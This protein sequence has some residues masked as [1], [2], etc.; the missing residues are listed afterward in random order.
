MYPDISRR[1]WVRVA[2]APLWVWAGRV[3]SALTIAAALVNAGGQ[4]VVN[5]GYRIPPYRQTEQY[6]PSVLGKYQWIAGK[7]EG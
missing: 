3:G 1:K 7:G 2:A 6:V 4:A 5:A